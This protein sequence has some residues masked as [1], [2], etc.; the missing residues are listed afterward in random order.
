[1][2]KAALVFYPEV[3]VGFNKT[4]LIE[5]R[6]FSTGIIGSRFNASPAFT[7]GT[8]YRQ[9]LPKN[10]TLQRYRYG[11]IRI[12][13]QAV[14]QWVTSGGLLLD[15]TNMVIVEGDAFIASNKQCARL[16]EFL[17]G[18]TGDKYTV[19]IVADVGCLGIRET[20]PEYLVNKFIAREG[21]S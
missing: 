9:Y 6:L 3:L 7:A 10:E 17:G 20:E 13:I 8:V 5:R 1:M 12:Y 19:D 18:I 11:I 14:G 21:F 4:Q 16:C 15:R 2:Y